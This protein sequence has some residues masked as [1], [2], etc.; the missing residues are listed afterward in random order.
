MTAEKSYSRIPYHQYSNFY[1]G[2]NLDTLKLVEPALYQYLSSY[3]NQLEK[4]ELLLIDN[5]P[6]KARDAENNYWTLKPP[7]NLIQALHTKLDAIQKQ[8]PSLLLLAGSGYGAELTLMHEFVQNLT[9]TIVVVVEHD[10]LNI[11]LA[12]SICDLRKILLSGIITWSIGEPIV[13]TLTK[14][15]KDNA[16][17]LV[18][19]NNIEMLFSSTAQDQSTKNQYIQG[20]QQSIQE[21]A[22]W[23]KN[24]NAITAKSTENLNRR[25]DNLSHVWSAGSPT[26]YTA[27]P[28]LL[29]IHRGL[30]A[31]DIQSAFT[32]LPC[33]RSRRLVQY[34]GQMQ[35]NPDAILFLNDPTRCY[36]PDGAF[37]RITWVT[38]D[39]S[40]RKNYQ[41]APRYDAEEL[42]LYADQTYKEELIRQGAQRLKHF[43]VFALLEREGTFKQELAYPL[44]FVGI[45]WNMAPFLS[46]LKTQDRDLLE[47]TYAEGLQLKTGT[48]GLKALWSQREIPASLL[49]C[50]AQLY[51]KCGR[52]HQ[53]ASETL[54]Y[55]V[56]MLDIYH[57]RWNMTQ[58]LLP[59]GLHVYGNYDW[60]PLLG[61][62]YADRYH[63]FIPYHQLADLYR[64]AQVVIGIH[65]LQLP[66]A[67]NIRD[68][69]VL[70]AGGCLLSDPVDG[71]SEDAILAGRDCETATTTAEFTEKA[72]LLLNDE[73]RRNQLSTNGRQTILDRYLPHHRAKIIVDAFQ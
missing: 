30:E 56:Y 45:T 18:F 48:S 49:T 21:I 16:L 17:F 27:T 10:P 19:S 60:K 7:E 51:E 1:L 31:F 26:E 36:V 50:A 42:V 38:D 14:A 52:R 6:E 62:K 47:E 70:M 15:I 43:P 2:N 32:F 40:F 39:P 23:C 68:C 4:I 67:I 34:Y 33:G 54:A 29:A 11:L 9:E 44:V 24:K 65:S 71:M 35:T 46:S 41:V 13:E 73:D 12:M 66:T 53:E 5:I 20:F 69:D 72:A 8:K 58:A 57:R 37:H 25:P 22:E 63:G 55:V 64:S 3:I 61:D 59:L 28:I